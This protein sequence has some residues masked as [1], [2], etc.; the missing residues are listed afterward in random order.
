MADLKNNQT[1]EQTMAA[2]KPTRSDA[3]REIMREPIRAALL[4]LGAGVDY[5]DELA[6]KIVQHQTIALSDA[7]LLVLQ[8]A[9]K[10]P[11]PFPV[12]PSEGEG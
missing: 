1:E 12:F 2:P 3:V 4:A 5:A 6:A 7:G 10:P 8:M 11:S 9:P